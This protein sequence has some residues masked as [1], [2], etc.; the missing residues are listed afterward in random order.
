MLYVVCRIGTS[1]YALPAEA[2]EKVL[3]FAALKPL[4]GAVRGLVG[5]LNFQ[6]DPVPV[7]D[8]DLLFHGTP[9]P[10]VF[11]SRIVLCRTPELLSGRL[12]LLV[13]FIE[14]VSTIPEESFAPS[15]AVADPALGGVSPA[16][17]SFIQRIE[18]P[19]VLPDNVLAG[20]D[21]REA[22]EAA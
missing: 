13:G 11:G 12:G 10:E 8:L 22:G 20:L 15:G 21:W 2:V 6:G 14:G 3:P 7:V 1:A 4:P 9:A 19:G 18:L 5:V 17:G 16:G